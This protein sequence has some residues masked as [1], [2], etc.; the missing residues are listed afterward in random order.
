LLFAF[1]GFGDNAAIFQTLESSLTLRY[2]IVS[3]DLPFHGK[4]KWKENTC[5][6]TEDMIGFVHHVLSQHNK[7][8][9]S[10]AG[11]SLG[12]K[13]C[14]A[15]YH[16]LPELVNRIFLFAPDG[17]KNNI[18]YNIAVY[19]KPGRALFRYILNK[20]HL[21]LSFVQLLSSLRIIPKQ[22]AQFLH[23]QLESK[24]KRE[25]VWSIWMCLRGYERNSAELKK[26]ILQ[27]HTRLLI[28]TGR[29]DNIIKSSFAEKFC[30]GLSTA[31]HIIIDKG[32]YLLK[33][34]LNP[35][36]SERI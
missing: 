15:I 7:N 34:Y 13:V 21:F 2:T 23:K 26:L 32:H 33:D 1:H 36:I 17:L 28:I 11:F 5:L 25:L 10:L 9:F 4:S 19:P 29:Y 20:P 3:V 18:W 30:K 12:G 6:T 22:Y 14:L 16:S 24:S 35:Y 31:E 8:K 27:H